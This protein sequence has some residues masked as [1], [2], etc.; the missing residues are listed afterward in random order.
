VT[1]P[2]ERRYLIFIRDS[3]DRIR[4]YAPR[5][6]TDFMADEAAQDAIVWRLQ[7]IGDA[8]RSHLTDDLKRRYPQIRWSAIYG[9]RNIAAHDYAGIDLILVWRIVTEDLDSL[10]T[11]V[12]NEL[13]G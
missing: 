11:V 3:I 6:E 10:H 4:R 8:A 12:V 5:T 9:F 13:G 1:L 7:I 2:H